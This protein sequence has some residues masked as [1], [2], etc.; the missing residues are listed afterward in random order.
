VPP[1]AENAKE[2][3]FPFHKFSDMEP[4]MDYK[5]LQNAE[6]RAIRDIPCIRKYPGIHYGFKVVLGN[7]F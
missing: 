7:C 4:C 5:A 6:V 3:A 1:P 2:R